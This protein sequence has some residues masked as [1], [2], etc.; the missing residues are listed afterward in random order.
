MLVKQSLLIYFELILSLLDL[1]SL[2]YKL[3][4]PLIAFIVDW[5]FLFY[6]QTLLKLNK[7][8][9]IYFDTLH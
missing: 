4:S 6:L 1:E 5:L 7:Y 3:P 9:F 2:Y 8:I